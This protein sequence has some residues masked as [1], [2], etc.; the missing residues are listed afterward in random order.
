MKLG[1]LEVEVK[2]E[3]LACFEDR[4]NPEDCFECGKGK[5]IFKFKKRGYF[6]VKCDEPKKESYCL[7]RNN[8]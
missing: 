8:Y 2:C 7:E 6:L 5:I 4:E 3:D 1:N